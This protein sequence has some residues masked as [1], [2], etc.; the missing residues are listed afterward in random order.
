MVDVAL[1]EAVAVVVRLEA[2]VR[3]RRQNQVDKVVA[4]PVVRVDAA[5]PRGIAVP[6][7]RSRLALWSRLALQ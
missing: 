4:G 5:A 6:I 3:H 7:R 1:V 2:V